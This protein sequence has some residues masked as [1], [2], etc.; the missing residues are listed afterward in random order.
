MN[1]VIFLSKFQII[2]KQKLLEKDEQAS[3]LGGHGND[4]ER[5]SEFFQS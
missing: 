4:F 1:I 3:L 5:M 2:H